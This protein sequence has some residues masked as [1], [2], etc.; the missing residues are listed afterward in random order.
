MVSDCPSKRRGGEKGPDGDVWE[1]KPGG[2][3][4]EDLDMGS[5]GGKGDRD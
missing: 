3:P 2:L 5:D 4:E 1:V